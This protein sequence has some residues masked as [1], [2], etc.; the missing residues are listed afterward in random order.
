[1][2][3]DDEDI[4]MS[5]IDLNVN[6]LNLNV[7]HLYLLSIDSGVIPSKSNQTVATA[8][9]NARFAT[10]S[11]QELNNIVTNADS[12]NTKA[13]T[14]WAVNAFKGG[15]I[16]SFYFDHFG[17]SNYGGLI[18]AQTLLESCFTLYSL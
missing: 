16:L 8:A 2:Q 11:N 5:T 17:F 3:E 15:Q 12:R 4:F 1:M 10:L 9:S 7:N 6:E 13:N 18:L 14:E